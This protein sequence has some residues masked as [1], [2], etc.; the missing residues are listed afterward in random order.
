R[1]CK[2][3]GKTSAADS[4]PVDLGPDVTY[5][6]WSDHL[7]PEGGQMRFWLGVSCFWFLLCGGRSTAQVTTA[8]IYGTVTDPTGAIVPG[9]NVTLRHE[10]TGGSF[11]KPTGDGG[12]FQ[13]DFLRVGT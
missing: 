5:S 8:T 11:S 2:L 12:D 6:D 9:A 10:Q 4:T 3:L 7:R 1:R 13:F